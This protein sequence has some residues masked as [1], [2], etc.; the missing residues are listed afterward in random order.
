MAPF[1]LLKQAFLA[2]RRDHASYLAAAISYHAIFS[3]A[4]LFIIV[5]AITGAIYGR[6][7]T[8]QQF[9]TL[10]QDFI[11]RDSAI[12][13]Q[14]LLE[15]ADLGSRSGTAFV[16]GVVLTLI[17]SIGVFKQLQQAVTMIWK[18][19]IKKRTIKM[20]ITRYLLLF[21]LVLVSSLLLIASLITSAVISKTGI[22]LSLFLGLDAP[23]ILSLTNT[24]ASLG[25]ITLLFAI[26]FRTLPDTPVL[27]WR[28]IFP[29]AVC[30]AILFN[31]G[32]YAIGLYLGR[33]SIGSA[34]GAAGSLV[35]LLIWVFYAAQIFLYGIELVKVQHSLPKKPGV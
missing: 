5:L 23:W 1:L 22:A 2:W 18:G 13:I 32:K 11:G 26:L 14:Q 6:E 9:I 24:I 21:V 8:Q 17:G 12:L 7:S 33:S 16:V 29:A 28:K 25:L 4:P 3:L 10:L 19:P 15:K 34:Y 30:T 27:E 31:I 35:A 20:R